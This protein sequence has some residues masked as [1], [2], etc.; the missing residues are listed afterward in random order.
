[1]SLQ[2]DS[3]PCTLHYHMNGGLVVVGKATIMK[4]KDRSFHGRQ[5]PNNALRVSVASVKQGYEGLCLPM[6]IGG[7]DDETPTQ[8]GKSKN[9]PI[10]WPKNLIRLEVV[11]SNPK[12][13]EQGMTT[14]PPTQL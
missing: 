7:E 11:G 4:P 1:M 13:P 8:L 12:G 6:N 14:T 2:A 9:W 10:L 5:M 3:I